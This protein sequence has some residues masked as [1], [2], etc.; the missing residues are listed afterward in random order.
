MES[1]ENFELYSNK[2]IDTKDDNFWIDNAT[3]L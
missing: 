3:N 1:N 2:E